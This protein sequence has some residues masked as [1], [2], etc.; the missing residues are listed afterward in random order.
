M[1]K[2]II[3]DAYG[4][5]ISTGSGSIEATQKILALNNCKSVSAEEFYSK[6]KKYH[7]INIDSL[8]TFLNEEA[9]FKLDLTLLYNEFNFTRNPNEDISIM[10][11]TLGKRQAFAEVNSVLDKLPKEIIVCI[12]ST[13]DT[14]PLLSDIKRNKININKIYT[15]E[16]LKAYKPQAAF[17]QSILKDLKINPEEALFVGDSYIDDIIGP[18]KAGIKTCFVNRKNS[19][20]GNVLPDF[21]IKDLK[22]LLQIVNSLTL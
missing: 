22:G 16:M 18:A 2:A 12:G 6:W 9:I 10:L 13:S 14:K 4:T 5:L 3:F 7:R 1:L 15:S 19:E 21:E 20:P 8:E 17:Y 11:N